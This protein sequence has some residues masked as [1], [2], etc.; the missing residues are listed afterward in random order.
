LCLIGMSILAAG[1]AAAGPWPVNIHATAHKQI[2]FDPNWNFDS[3]CFTATGDLTEVLNASAHALASGIDA[4]GNFVA[5]MHVTQN[6][7]E[8][9]HFVPYDK[10]L[11]TYHGRAVVHTTNEENSPRAGFTNTV[12]LWGSDG[13]HFVMHENLRIVV[14][15]NGIDLFT[16]H[17]SV[18]C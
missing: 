4:D 18:H 13:S 16:D 17:T 3:P 2:E 8:T 5:P 9:V 14:K 15:A 1:P 12:V 7:T 10:S 11:P 6:V